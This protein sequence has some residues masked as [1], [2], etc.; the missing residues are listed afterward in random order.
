[1]AEYKVHLRYFVGDPLETIR[2]EDLDLI[3]GRFGVEMAVNKIDNR[4]F[5]DGMMR[6]ETLGRAIE[7]ITQDVITVV[8]GDEAALRGV[9]AEVY[10]RYRSPRTPYGFWGS[11][12]EGRDVARDLIEETGGGW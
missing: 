2:Q 1:M 8:A 5:K 12:E 10:D 11:T 6:E 9:L 7:D 4:E 3:A